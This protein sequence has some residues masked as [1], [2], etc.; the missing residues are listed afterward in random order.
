MGQDLCIECGGGVVN[1]RVGA[2]ILKDGKFL[3]AGNPNSDYLYSIGGRI[4]F[5]ETAEQ[6]VVRE[7]REETGRDMEIDRLGFVT[8]DFFYGDSPAHL[9]KLIY[10][11]GYYY[12]MKTPADFEPVCESFTEAGEKE[13]SSGSRRRSEGS[14]IPLSSTTSCAI[15]KRLSDTLSQTRDKKTGASHGAPVYCLFAGRF[16]LFTLCPFPAPG[17]QRH[18]QHGQ[19]DHAH[20][21]DRDPEGHVVLVAGRDAAAVDIRNGEDRKRLAVLVGHADNMLARGKTL[22]VGGLELDD[23]AAGCSG[24]IG[25]I[26]RLAVHGQLG[27]LAERAVRSKAELARRAFAPAAARAIGDEIIRKIE[28]RDDRAAVCTLERD[29]GG[30][31]LRRD[32][33]QERNVVVLPFLERRVAVFHLDRRLDALVLRLAGGDELGHRTA[34]DRRDGKALFHAAGIVARARDRDLGRILAD[35]DVVGIA[36]NGE[37]LVLLQ[38]ALAVLERDGRLARRAGIGHLGGGKRDHLRCDRFRGKCD[39]MRVALGRFC[40]LAL[41]IGKEDREAVAD[42]GERARRLDGEAALNGHFILCGAAVAERDEV[43][44]GNAVDRVVRERDRRP[45]DRKP[46]AARLRRQRRAGGR[47]QRRAPCLLALAGLFV[48]IAV[49]GRLIAFAVTRSFA[50][51]ALAGRLG[52]LRLFDEGHN[53]RILDRAVRRGRSR[54]VER[55]AVLCLARDEQRVVLAADAGGPV[56]GDPG[57]LLVHFLAVLV[58]HNG[59]V[60]RRGSPLLRDHDGIAAA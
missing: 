35:L 24:I 40:L 57:D 43:W 11:L 55:A 53:D 32:V 13:F 34:G 28:A 42:I 44:P 8:E 26:D 51:H 1:I 41:G 3:M 12:Y 56:S 45:D 23:R 5:G 58:G 27:E 18:A 52:L 59:A 14:S 7:V 9:G 37:V 6:A 54:D 10:E 30:A 50:V 39:G 16:L 49:A 46:L 31:A 48:F 22:E 21:K 38:R 17:G 4:Q 15:R 60:A 2:I 19:S 25:R 36:R 20:P 47:Q 29:R 33:I